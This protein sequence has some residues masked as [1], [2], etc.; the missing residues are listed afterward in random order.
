MRIVIRDQLDHPSRFGILCHE[1]AHI[2][3]GHLGSD[4]DRWWPARA[5]LSRKTMEMEA[6]AV[7]FI[8]TQR[9]GVRCN[10]GAEYKRTETKFLVPVP[11]A[12]QIRVY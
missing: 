1:I 7:A 9:F 4:W 12:N 2:L 6:E 5:N 10:C 8:V 11:I 3:L